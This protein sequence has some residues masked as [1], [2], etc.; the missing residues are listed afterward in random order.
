MNQDTSKLSPEQW[1]QQVIDRLNRGKMPRRDSKLGKLL[2]AAESGLK[3]DQGDSITGAASIRIAIA[4]QLLVLVSELPALKPDKPELSP[5]FRWAVDAL[6]ETLSELE[7]PGQ[8]KPK[9]RNQIDLEAI[10]GDSN[11]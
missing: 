2:Y 3:D 11:E 8:A 7:K 4:L 5:S 1:A 9:A 6:R 10:L